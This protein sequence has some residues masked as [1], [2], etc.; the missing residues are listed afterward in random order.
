MPASCQRRSQQVVAMSSSVHTHPLNAVSGCKLPT[1]VYQTFVHA[2]VLLPSLF[3]PSS[4]SSPPSPP[5]HLSSSS[6]SLPHNL[7]IPMML[8]EIT[9]SSF[10]AYKEAVSKKK[11]FALPQHQPCWVHSAPNNQKESN[12]TYNIPIFLSPSF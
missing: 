5:P 10:S 12:H 8:M 9:F 7:A 1:A 11:L 6:F 2:P 3:L 4:F